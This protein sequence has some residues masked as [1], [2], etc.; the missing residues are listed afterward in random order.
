MKWTYLTDNKLNCGA[1]PLSVSNHNDLRIYIWD[2]HNVLASCRNMNFFFF[3]E[4]SFSNVNYF[5]SEVFIFKLKSL[6]VQ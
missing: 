5:Y 1:F 3:F 6:G 2:F 4:D